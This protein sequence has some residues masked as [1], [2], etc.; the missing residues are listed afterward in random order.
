MPQIPI[1][2]VALDPGAGV[3][4]TPK[5]PPQGDYDAVYR[6]AMS[7]RWDGDAFT[8]HMLPRSDRTPVEA[9]QRIVAEVAKEYG[10]QLVLTP[11][12]AWQDISPADQ[13]AIRASFAGLPR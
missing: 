7:V 8:L 13:A 11:E 1:D 2:E 10:D 12:T 9:F 4:I 5:L 6:G 3:R